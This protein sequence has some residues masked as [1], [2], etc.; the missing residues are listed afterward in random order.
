MT[1]FGYTPEEW[2]AYMADMRSSYTESWSK[3]DQA[4][5]AEHLTGNDEATVRARVEWFRARRGEREG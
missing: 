1:P 3:E 4:Y 5:F 2:A